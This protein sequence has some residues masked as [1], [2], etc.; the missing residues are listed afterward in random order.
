MHVADA[1]S[2]CKESKFEVL[3][4]IRNFFNVF[5]NMFKIPA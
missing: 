2:T 1:S 4:S 5:V 3:S